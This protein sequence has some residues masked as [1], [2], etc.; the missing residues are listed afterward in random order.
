MNKKYILLIFAGLLFFTS[1]KL[2]AQIKDSTINIWQFEINYS[3]QFPGGDMAERFGPNSTVGAGLTY[4]TK[5]NY[6]FGFEVGYLFGSDIKDGTTILDAL[7]TETGQII[8]EYGEYGS[9][10][11]SERGFYSGVKFGKLFPI[12]APNPNSGFI[13]NIGAGLLQHHIRIENKDNNTP[14][15]LGDYKKGYD[16]LTNGLCLREFV[17]YQFLSNNN[18]VNVYAG[19]EFYQAWTMN[20]RDID[21]DTMKKDNTKRNDY[22]YGIRIGLILPIYRRTPDQYYYY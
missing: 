10:L 17:G 18:T 2:S 4:K 5:L 1:N 8:N 20:R 7:K 11:L 12:L 21:F 19:F 15:V 16:R 14:P 6:T 3:F 9:I 13:V 22:L